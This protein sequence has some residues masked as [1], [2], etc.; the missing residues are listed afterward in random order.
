MK[1]RLE[2]QIEK[3]QNEIDEIKN[4]SRVM[5][6]RFIDDFNEKIVPIL[7]K[8]NTGVE[9]PNENTFVDKTLVGEQKYIFRVYLNVN[10]HLLTDLQRKNLEKKL[11]EVGVPMPICPISLNSISLVYHD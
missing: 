10:L 5:Q 9:N 2:L 8:Y 6:R 4:F 11:R 7:K 1:T 3:M